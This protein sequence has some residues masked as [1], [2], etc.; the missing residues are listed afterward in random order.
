MCSFPFINIFN[1]ITEAL[2]THHAD[3]NLQKVPVTNSWLFLTLRSLVIKTSHV[4]THC[5]ICLFQGILCFFFF[6]TLF[7]FYY[8]PLSLGK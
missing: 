8:G 4:K 5:D 7:V 6:P 2:N 3:Y 1:M